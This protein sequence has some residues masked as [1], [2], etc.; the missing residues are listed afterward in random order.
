MNRRDDYLYPDEENMTPTSLL[1]DA[2]EHLI[3]GN[4]DE[5]RRGF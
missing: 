3:E 1:G 5:V 2:C 4:S